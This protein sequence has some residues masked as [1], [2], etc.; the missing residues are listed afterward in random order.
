MIFCGWQGN[1]QWQY[2]HMTNYCTKQRSCWLAQSIGQRKGH[3]MNMQLTNNL[4]KWHCPWKSSKSS[5]FLKVLAAFGQELGKKFNKKCN[6]HIIC[7]ILFQ[8]VVS[9]IS[10]PFPRSQKII[11]SILLGLQT[12]P[13]GLGF[14]PTST[15]Q[16]TVQ[17]T[18]IIT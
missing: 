11:G 1:C 2:S 3:P 13:P 4:L 6:F 9:V 10:V 14:C 17:C 16:S 5:G 15:I 8:T 18:M 12:T 7:W